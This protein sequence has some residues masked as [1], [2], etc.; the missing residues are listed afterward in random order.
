LKIKSLIRTFKP[1]IVHT[2][3]AKSGAIG[4]LAAFSCRV[5]VVVH[6]FHGHVFHSYF[7]K[8]KTKTFINIERYLAARSSG[9]IAISQLQK[10]ELADA[11]R[12]CPPEKIHIIPLGLDL[13]KFDRQMAQKRAAFRHRYHIAPDEIAIGIIG[14]IVPVKNHGLFVAASARMLAKTNAKVRLVIVGDGDMRAQMEAKLAAENIT[15][16]YAPQDDNFS[17]T[18][19]C[20][21]WLTEMDETLA[22]LDIVALTSHNEGTP[23]SLIEAQAAGKPV[24]STHVGGVADVVLQGKTGFI[25]ERGNVEAFAGALL[26]LVQQEQLRTAFGQAGRVHVHAHFSYQRL[27]GDMAAYYYRLLGH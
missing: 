14:R 16:R 15:Y 22:G 20:T 6:T 9:I 12:I 27:V 11:Y 1:D 10:Q 19:I 21:S 25:T 8:L 2:H 24:A 23:L 7:N 5:P 4:R 26:Q 3:A 17:A 13:D 18:A